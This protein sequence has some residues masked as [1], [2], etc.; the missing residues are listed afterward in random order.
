MATFIQAN[1]TIQKSTSPKSFEVIGPNHK[2]TIA[3]SLGSGNF[4]FNQNKATDFAVNSTSQTIMHLHQASGHPSYEYFKQMYPNR[5][6]SHLDCSTYN[7]SK[8]TKI[9][10]KG[11][12]PTFHQ[13]L[14]F[15]TWTYVVP[16]HQP[17]FP[18]LN[19]S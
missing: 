11:T 1:H 7:T 15:Y 2:I 4:V 16:S 19:T 9:P 13:K 10:F 12:F 3:G 14:N 5:Q 17:Q 8:M 6:I 18:E